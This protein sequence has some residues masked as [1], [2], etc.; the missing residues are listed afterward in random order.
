MSS[1]EPLRFGVRS[2]DIEV[3]IVGSE[4]VVRR[5]GLAADLFS[6]IGL[7]DREQRLPMALATA[8]YTGGVLRIYRSGQPWLVL[9]GV[10]DHYIAM[11][12]AE[13]IRRFS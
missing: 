6:A 1:D 7:L 2:G 9:D 3:G 11:D 8:H 5:V 12:L 13:E 4:I 10:R